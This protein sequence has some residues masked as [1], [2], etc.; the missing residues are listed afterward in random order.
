MFWWGL[1][2][3]CLFGGSVGFITLSLMIV[4]KESD[5]EMEG[6]AYERAFENIEKHV[7]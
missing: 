4:A 5:N 2:L 3:G 1:F 7:E 6:Y